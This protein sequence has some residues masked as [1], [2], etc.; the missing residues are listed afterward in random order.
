MSLIETFEI[1]RPSIVALGARIGMGKSSQPPIFPTLFGT[2]FVVDPRGIVATNRHVV[3]E[4]IKLPRDQRDD[5][6]L[7]FAM[8]SGPTIDTP[9]GHQQMTF[10]AGIKY[11]GV[12][13]KFAWSQEYYG[14]PLPDIAFVQLNVCNIPTLQLAT[15]PN[16]WRIG[17]PIATAGFPLGELALTIYGNVNQITPFLR[18]GI[19]SSLFPFQTP[20]PHGFSID[21]MSQ[22]GASGSPVFLT[23]SPTVVGILH[24]GF[25]QANI[26]IILPSQI[27]AEA[28]S[29]SF[30]QLSFDFSNVPTLEDAIK[31]H[32][33]LTGF[34]WTP[35]Q[36]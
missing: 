13:D 7:A 24:A 19:I 12:L 30:S 11:Y 31:A 29:T 34:G 2:G 6:S 33:G 23:D 9:N 15:E 17:M 27:I 28:L 20:F 25:P 35:F 36:P 1:V 18:Q 21:I 22:P 8:I 32:S 3:E 4:L 16:T 10:L 14:D 26:T 5:S